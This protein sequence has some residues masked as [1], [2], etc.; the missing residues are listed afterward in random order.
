[1]EK[2][3]S[4]ADANRKFSQLLR[5]VRQ[6]SSYVVTSHGRPLAQIVPLHSNQL[7]AR[8]RASC[9]YSDCGEKP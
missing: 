3:V 1:M 5:E 8:G 6:G 9:C 4:A 2:T 7:P